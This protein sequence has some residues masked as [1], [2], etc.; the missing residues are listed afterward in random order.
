M[1][2]P[3]ASPA[4]AASS[5]QQRGAGALAPSRWLGLAR[6]GWAIT[7]LLA[8]GIYVASIP[9]DVIGFG[10]NP[11]PGR[12]IDAPAGLVHVIILGASLILFAAAPVCL[13]LAGLLAWRKPGDL[14]ALF[15]SFYLLLY[16][17]IWVGPLDNLYRLISGAGLDILHDQI[18]ALHP[19]AF[20]WATLVLLAL[21]PTGRFVPSWTRWLVLLATLT[22]PLLVSIFFQGQPLPNLWLLWPAVIYMSLTLAA[23]GYAQVYRYRHLS[24]PPARQQTKW[25]VSGLVVAVLLIQVEVVLFAT[26]ASWPPGAALP[27]WT[28][29]FGLLHALDVSVVPLTLTVAVLYY[30]VFDIDVLIRRTLVYATLTVILVAVYVAGVLSAQ[31]AVQALTGQT[32]Q[33]P[34]FIVAS[35]L[36]VAALFSPL[37]RRLQAGIDRR[38]Y[39]RKYVAAR[40]LEAFG[41]TLRAQTDLAQLSEQ[42][43]AVVQETLQPAHISLWLRPPSDGLPDGSPS[44]L[45]RPSEPVGAG[46]TWTVTADSAEPA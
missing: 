17:V 8:L 26:L 3:R 45:S 30:R 34:V 40:T 42:L 44:T 2:T 20:W 14:M 12:G 19:L 22:T 37:R 23:A 32:G 5:D 29:G 25:A 11:F 33:Q 38:F 6:A 10:A 21:F 15:V 24:S 13:G 46:T 1:T 9:A 18:N 4:A 35:T 27:W 7:A 28:P 36:L 41:A 39:R 43:V 16:G 31:A